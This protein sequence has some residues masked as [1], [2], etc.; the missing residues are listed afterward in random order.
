MLL[1]GCSHVGA[2]GGAVLVGGE[3][4]IRNFSYNVMCVAQNTN[5]NVQ[6]LVIGPKTYTKEAHET[7]V[8]GPYKMT[9]I[10]PG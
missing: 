6:R 2:G 10:P 5:S 3:N 8:S 1:S 4:T 7:V 9:I